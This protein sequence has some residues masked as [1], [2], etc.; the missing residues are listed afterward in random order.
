VPMPLRARRVPLRH[1]P[2][3]ARSFAATLAFGVGLLWRSAPFPSVAVCDDAPEQEPGPA[4]HA[5]PVQPGTNYALLGERR[6]AR[7]WPA[8]ARDNIAAI[9]LDAA[10]RGPDALAVRARWRHIVASARAGAPPPTPAGPSGPTRPSRRSW[11][12]AVRW[13]YDYRPEPG[14]PETFER[15]ALVKPDIE[16]VTVANSGHVPTL[17]EPEA[18]AAIITGGQSAV[19][20]NYLAFTRAHE[21]AADQ[22]ALG[23]LDKL[24]ISAAGLLKVFELLRRHGKP[25]YA[26]ETSMDA[27]EGIFLDG[28]PFMTLMPGM[29]DYDLRIRAMDEDGVWAEL[30]FPTFP[31]FC[32]AKRRDAAAILWT[33][34]AVSSRPETGVWVC[35]YTPGRSVKMVGV[36]VG[37]DH[38][39][40]RSPSIGNGTG[41]TLGPALCFASRLG[42]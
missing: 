38:D 8:R 39:S 2:I 9:T 40:A 15:M 34:S 23:A 30:L 5:A 35:H 26:V 18:A 22:S 13:P 7:G 6:L 24:N 19:A 29:F 21:E 17:N 36:W 11:P 4:A 20:R 25:R 3:R 10:G 16:R 12:P 14:S 37:C 31:R 28:A 42:V 33:S 32:G 41:V 27:A 1:A